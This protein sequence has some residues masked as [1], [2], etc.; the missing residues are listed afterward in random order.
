MTSAVVSDASVSAVRQK[1]H[2]VFPG[3]RAKRPAVAEDYGL[4][5]APVLVVDLG[6][7]FCRD[8][9]HKMFS[10]GFDFYSRNR[11]LLTGR[12]NASKPCLATHH[13]LVG[14]GGALQ[15]IDLG[16]GPHTG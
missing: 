1:Q 16:H 6:T 2:L 14:F 11:R 13:A 3:V 5:R 8:C 15:R 7:V 12:Q 10:L 9:R 4:S